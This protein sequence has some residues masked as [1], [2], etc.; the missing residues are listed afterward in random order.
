MMPGCWA[1]LPVAHAGTS[2]HLSPGLAGAAGQA[3]SGTLVVRGPKIAVALI[4]DRPMSANV[5]SCTLGA[6][7]P[8]QPMNFVALES[9]EPG[10]RITAPPGVKSK[11]QGVN[12]EPLRVRPH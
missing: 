4:A 5:H 6:Q 1:R 9:F 7:L 10:A 3:D 2:I 12:T 11:L 8:L